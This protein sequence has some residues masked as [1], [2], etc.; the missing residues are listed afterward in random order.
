MRSRHVLALLLTDAVEN[1]VG[2]EMS[3]GVVAGVW[4]AA[5]IGDTMRALLNKKVLVTAFFRVVKEPNKE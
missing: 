3:H 5:A 4:R 1:R 2:L